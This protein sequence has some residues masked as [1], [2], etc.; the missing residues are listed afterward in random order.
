MTS[1][2]LVCCSKGTSSF[3]DL[4]RFQEICSEKIG[5]ICFAIYLWGAFMLGFKSLKNIGSSELSRFT[6]NFARSST[7]SL[8]GM[9]IWPGTQQKKILSSRWTVLLLVS[10]LSQ[11]TISPTKGWS[12]WGFFQSLHC[13]KWVGEDSRWTVV[14]KPGNDFSNQR[15]IGMGV[16]QSLH[17][18]KWVGENY[19]VF[20]DR[21]FNE[22]QCYKRSARSSG[23]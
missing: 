21:A 14:S 20:F 3:W 6:A 9:P 23:E 17:C 22:F 12:G 4:V 11:E 1:S 13:R 5:S 16:F 2:F 18:R 7:C 19:E 15:M 8:P 10:Q